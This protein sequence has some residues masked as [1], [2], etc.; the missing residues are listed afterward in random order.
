MN[1]N[2]S[3]SPAFVPIA[4]GVVVLLLLISLAAGSAVP[5]GPLSIV[6]GPVQRVLNN[7]GRAISGFFRPLSEP[8]VSQSQLD[9]LKQQITALS[10]ENV[11]LREN[12]IELRQLRDLLKFTQ[13]NPAL[14]FVGADVIGVGGRDCE[15]Q[16]TVGSNVGVCAAVIAG[17]PSPYVR[18]LTINAG[19]AQGLR[20]GMPVI[21]GGGVLIGRIGRVVNANT[22]HIQLINDPASFI[23]VQM[24]GTRA[25]GTVAGQP[26]GT[27]RLQNV[28]QTETVKEGDLIV[29]SGLG[30]GLPA[31]LSVGQ[32]DAIVSK[33]LETL[34]EATVR[35]GTDLRRIE[36]VIVLLF[37]PPRT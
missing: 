30:G 12:A 31:G 36:H 1:R 16:P 32:V 33:E 35:P 13:S 17:D 26:D 11:R 5:Q 37:D 34:K 25:V 21:G 18:S 23:V 7:A 20:T 6:T 22:S 2:R 14:E 10:N 28:L 3:G 29:T 27:L 24:V 9:A 4:L 8:A 19:S 15:G